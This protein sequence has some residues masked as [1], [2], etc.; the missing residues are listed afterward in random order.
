[1][2]FYKGRDEGTEI[3]IKI[4]EVLQTS[5]T[6]RPNKYKIYVEGTRAECERISDKI[7][8]NIKEQR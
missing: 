5:T 2:N 3:E 8:K 4:V 6:T 1:M 7:L